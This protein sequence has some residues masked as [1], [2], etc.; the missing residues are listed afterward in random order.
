[1]EG[2]LDP[3]LVL[4]EPGNQNYLLTG[5]SYKGEVVTK[6][7]TTLAKVNMS[8]QQQPLRFLTVGAIATIG[9]ELSSANKCR[10][11]SAPPPLFIVQSGSSGSRSRRRAERYKRHSWIGRS[12]LDLEDSSPTGSDS[13]PR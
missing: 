4:L 11:P 10:R 1:M 8:P 3:V 2:P 12:V 5:F 7:N 6:S 13:L 9:I